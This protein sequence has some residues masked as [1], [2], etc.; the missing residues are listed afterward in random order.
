MANVQKVL[1]FFPNVCEDQILRLNSIIEDGQLSKKNKAIISWTTA[2]SNNAL[3]SLQE[4]KRRLE[5]FD[6]SF[7]DIEKRNLKDKELAIIKFAK[8]LTETP[9]IIV[10]KDVNDLKEFYNDFEVAEIVYL[11]GFFNF[12]DRF[13]E[14]LSFKVLD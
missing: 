10:D 11:I 4:S 6:I 3:F 8:K 12:L 7:I 9:Q 1:S 13:T 14:T 5:E 2:R